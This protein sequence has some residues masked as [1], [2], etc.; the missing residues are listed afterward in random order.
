M[1]SVN[2]LTSFYC[3]DE[4][5]GINSGKILE[6]PNVDIWETNGRWFKSNRGSHKEAHDFFKSWVFS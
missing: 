4:F 1:L 5:N 2:K 3:Y 6:F